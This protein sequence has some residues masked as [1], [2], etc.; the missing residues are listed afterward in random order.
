MAA[1]ED[2][3][4]LRRA[5]IGLPALLS[6]P[7][8]AQDF[9]SRPVRLVVPFAA[10][11]I[12]DVVARIVA[13]RLQGELGRPVLVENQ[14]GAGGTIGAA[15]VARAA[16]DGHTLLLH[17]TGHAVSRVLYP[18]FPFDPVRDFAPV[19][20][21]GLQPFVV[22]VHPGVPAND[23]PALLAWLR[24]RRGEANFGTT[25]IGAG[26]H[27]AGELLK[28]R[29][30]VDFTVVTYRGTP[31]AVTDLLAGRVQM[32][33]DSQ[34]LLAPLMR[35][36]GVRGLA[37]T[38]AVRSQM[39]PEL[40]TLR[41]AGVAD[42]DAS[43]WQALFAPAATPAPVLRRLAEALG[44]VMAD[45]AT[46]ARFAEA[47]VEVPADTSPAGLRAHLGAEMAKWEPVLRATGARAD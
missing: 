36:G 15:T 41:E 42:Y 18:S 14:G 16:P 20:L 19:G 4:M 7:A 25:G 46:R 45:P 27:L 30:G 47:G 6:L 3:P 23:V 12:V 37:V 33:I 29:A 9:P 24:Q 43:A 10:G 35:D 40:P 26:S 21:I 13:E 38:S 17:A 28:A 34:T 31:A 5:L 39:L 44:R 22:A 8:A 11:G 32:M 1:I 2:V